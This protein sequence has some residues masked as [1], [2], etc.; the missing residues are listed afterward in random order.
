[1]ISKL[2]PLAV[3]LGML[4][5][6]TAIAAPMPSGIDMKVTVPQSHV[7]HGQ[8]A[9]LT[10]VVTDKTLNAPNAVVDLEVYNAKGTRIGQN[11]W[12]AQ[13]LVKGKSSIYHWAWT[14]KA[15]GIYTV[16]LGVFGSGWK[17]LYHWDNQALMLKAY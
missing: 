7:K 4:I 6:G 10:V 16:K 12:Q 1:M 17:P 15:P 2:M 3:I 8:S 5:A 13:K 9:A 14:P 11:V